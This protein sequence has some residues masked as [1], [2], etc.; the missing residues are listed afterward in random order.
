M[1]NPLDRDEN[2]NARPDDEDDGDEL[3]GDDDEDDGD[4]GELEGDDGDAGEL[5]GDGGDGVET[6][7]DEPPAEG[8][9]RAFLSSLR[10]G[11]P[12]AIS[13]DLEIVEAKIIVQ[14][15][16]GPHAGKKF[17]IDLLNPKQKHSP[18]D[19]SP[20][21]HALIVA[22]ADDAEI[23]LDTV[24]HILEANGHDAP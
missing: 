23:V 8:G 17:R 20:F 12:F 5:E 1:P 6:V 18:Y 21:S 3:E 16:A 4:D 2:D 15:E 24:S 7:E 14:H 19:N 10:L 13:G 11:A 9:L 22:P